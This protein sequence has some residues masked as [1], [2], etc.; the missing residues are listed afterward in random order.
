VSA[1]GGAFTSV[2]VGAPGSPDGATFRKSPPYQFSFTIPNE[3]A[4]GPA[5]IDALGATAS[6]DVFADPVFI[7]VERADSPTRITLNHSSIELQAGDILPVSV[8]GTYADGST[9]NLTKSTQTKYEQTDTGVV[10]VRADG[11]LTALA[12]GTTT[13]E[14]RHKDKRAIVKVTVIPKQN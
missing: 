4:L 3:I 9:I 6:G 5:E 12:T 8:Y 14:V 2:S 10:S 1:A 7:D 13:I 11:L